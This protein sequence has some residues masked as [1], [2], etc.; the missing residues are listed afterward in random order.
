MDMS[1]PP[2]S[3]RKN[4]IQRIPIGFSTTCV[5]PT[6]TTPTHTFRIKQE[7]DAQE[8]YHVRIE[9]I[10]ACPVSDSAVLSSWFNPKKRRSGARSARCHIRAF[11]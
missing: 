3:L 4:C 11:H 1:F 5:Q 6:L 10:L 7:A 8:P 2:K 9:C